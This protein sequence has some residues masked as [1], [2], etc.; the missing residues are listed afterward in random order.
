MRRNN[1]SF[2][3]S[4]SASKYGTTLGHGFGVGGRRGLGKKFQPLAKETT[5]P[6]D[7]ESIPKDSEPKKP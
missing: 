5:V 3:N 1:R 2:G 7:N 6:K 4:T